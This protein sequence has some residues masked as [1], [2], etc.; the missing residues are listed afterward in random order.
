MHAGGARNVGGGDRPQQTTVATAKVFEVR[1]VAALVAMPRLQ[2]GAVLAHELCHA[3]MHLLRFPRLPALVAEGVCELW[4]WLWL[5]E[6]SGAEAA[7]RLERLVRN[8]DVV[9]GDGLRAA[10]A[11]WSG[12][13]GG[14]L[15]DFM[16]L[17]RQRRCWWAGGGGSTPLK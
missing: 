15:T 16:R 17:V 6:Q 7:A 4:A 10:V 8:P 1:G 13:G 11:C 9:Y 5:A 12:F 2:L 14:G 3:F